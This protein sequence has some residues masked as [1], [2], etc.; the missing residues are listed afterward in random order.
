MKRGIFH[1]AF[2]DS[3]GIVTGKVY[4]DVFRAKF[5]DTWSVRAVEKWVRINELEAIDCSLVFIVIESLFFP[6][7]V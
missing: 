3:V 1:N 4:H 5:L 7:S 2:D 6:P